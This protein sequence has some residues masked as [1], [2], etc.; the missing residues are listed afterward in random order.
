MMSAVVPTVRSARLVFTGA[1]PNGGNVIARTPGPQPIVGVQMMT[2]SSP[3]PLYN[4]ILTDPSNIIPASG[5]TLNGTPTTIPG[6]TVGGTVAIYSAGAITWGT[7]T[8]TFVGTNT[9]FGYHALAEVTTG[10]N[11][12]AFG[13]NALHDLTTGDNNSACGH[14]A[15]Q[16][17]TI[18]SRNTAVGANALSEQFFSEPSD[19]VAVGSGA[20]RYHTDGSQ[21]VAVGLNALDGKPGP[22]GSY[23][24]AD[25]AFGTNAMR[26]TTSTNFNCA[27]GT[28]ALEYAHQAACNCALGYR[29]LA[30]NDAFV[31]QPELNC[32]FGTH[33]LD[34]ASA[35]SYV[36]YNCALGA[37]AL[38]DPPSYLQGCTAVG[39]ETLC[40]LDE[41]SNYTTAFGSRAGKSLVSGGGTTLFGYNAG[42]VLT[43]G[44]QTTL[45]GDGAGDSV[46]IATDTTAVG[47]TVLVS[48]TES[49][50]TIAIGA[51]A[52][53]TNNAHTGTIALGFGAMPD[54]AERIAL[55]NSLNP[56]ATV[57]T[58]LQAGAA[59]PIAGDPVT[60]LVVNLNGNVRKIP[61]WLAPLS[62]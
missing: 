52:G 51:N 35:P 48:I 50:D 45:V 4:K 49:H 18:G 30:C 31:N 43:T 15:L 9:R 13:V 25:T 1:A 12:T 54:A 22:G 27:F 59:D 20:M 46:T 21:C 23:H 60:Y 36:R 6:P 32:A 57:T 28:S 62:P 16:H 26:G 58:G 33:A 8:D 37:Y 44:T 2:P 24:F 5:L 29:A 41:N 40:N 42:V 47:A 38:F 19:C 17:L 53:P 39:Y 7:F 14:N 11:N 56:L 3:M 34:C 61:L 10:V 55:A